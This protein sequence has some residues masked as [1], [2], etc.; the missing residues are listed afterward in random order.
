MTLR[1]RLL[2]GAVLVA[3]VVL[4]GSWAV[5]VRQGSFVLAETDARLERLLPVARAAARRLDD[6]AKA[7]QALVSAVSDAW[8]GRLSPGGEPV[9]LIAPTDDPSL[10]PDLG[11]AGLGDGPSTH[12]TVS[13]MSD[14]VRVISGV[15]GNGQRLVVAIPMD[16]GM[17]MLAGIR[18]ISLSLAAAVLALLALLVW[19]VNRLGIAPLAG[20]TEAARRIASGDTDHR[21]PSPEGNAEAAVLADALNAMVDGLKR[22]DE[23]IR[24]FVADASHELRT[25]LTTVR[26]YSDLYESGALHTEPQVADA[27]RRIRSEA[28]RMNRIV[29]DLLELRGVE[30]TLLSLALHRLDG[31]VAQCAADLRVAHPLRRIT[32]DTVECTVNVDA[33]RITQAVMALGT[34][35]VEHTH[36]DADIT[37]TVVTLPGTARLEVTDNG[38]GIAPEH[39]DRLFERLYR[40]DKARTAG[41]NSGI[42]LSVVAAIVRSHGGRHGVN[43]AP[44]KGA[45]FW[46][47]LPLPGN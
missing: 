6:R 16:D 2:L 9:T 30:E 11:P 38:P 13:G 28:D 36:D 14:T 12:G 19:W 27:M 46:F 29:S 33:A 34:N 8:I 44:G 5:S 17:E 4:G 21:V 35:A 45:M 39:L 25:P 26:G 23:R 41:A 40:A 20:M 32:V 24:Q 31:I 22:S 15:Q 1:S 37:M 47:E 7:P 3:L 43:S 42:G 10:V 18:R